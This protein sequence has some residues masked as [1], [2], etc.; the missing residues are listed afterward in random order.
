MDDIIGVD[1]DNTIVRYDDIMYKIAVERSLVQPNLPKNK[2]QIR[3][4][5][6]RLP[7]GEMKWQE[8]QATIYGLR[9][10]DAEIINGVEEFFIQCRLKKIRVYIISHKTEYASF[11]SARINLQNASLNWMMKKN[12]FSNDGLGLSEKNVF[13]E[14]GRSAKIERIKRLGCAY[15]IDDLEEIFLDKSFPNHVKKIL[16][17]PLSQDLHSKDIKAFKTWEEIN[18]Y[19]FK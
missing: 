15:F 8:L 5:I 19:F 13:F 14:P 3:D 1:F 11:N 16:Y 7:N 9:M 12:F 2:K 10:D 6:R 4:I 18:H 17:D